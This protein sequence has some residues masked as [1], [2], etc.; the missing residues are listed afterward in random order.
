[1]SFLFHRKD[2]VILTY[3]RECLSYEI[4]RSVQ[5]ADSRESLVEDVFNDYLIIGLL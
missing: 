1:M 4:N 5:D 2:L 3:E